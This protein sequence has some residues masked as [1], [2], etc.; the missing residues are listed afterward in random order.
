MPRNLETDLATLRSVQNLAEKRDFAG[1]AALA[2]RTLAEGFEHPML[3]NIAATRL[4]QEGKYQDALILLERAVAI[5]PKD[6]GARNALG[7]CL[8]RLDLPA[9][10]L[11]HIDEILKHHPELP[12]AHT[13]KGNALL[14]LGFLGRARESHLRAFELDPKNF[15]AAAALGSIAAHRGQYAEARAWAERTLAI[16]PGFPDAVLALS[17]AELAAGDRATPEKRLRDVINDARASPIDRARATGLLA[18]VLDAA[19]RYVEAFEAYDAGNR[20]WRQLYQHFESAN[21]IGYARAL[22]SAIEKLD[23]AGWM[24]SQE[25]RVAAGHVFL[26][27]FPRTGTTLVGVVLD[28]HP[29]SSASRNTNC[30]H[31]ACSPSCAS[32]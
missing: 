31:R 14:A 20:V 26:L 32:R 9:E 29:M 8:Q 13:N 21:V 24:D 23:S 27:G 1:A 15:S 22:S 10:A 4:E 11:Y 6:I 16:V 17:A 25:P 5:A 28:G 2:Q 19:G 12:F 3:L 30:W 18:D 7:L